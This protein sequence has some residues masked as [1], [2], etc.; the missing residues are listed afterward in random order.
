M[1]RLRRFLFVVALLPMCA[2]SEDVK[3][4]QDPSRSP[5]IGPEQRHL[6]VGS[7]PGTHDRPHTERHA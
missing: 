4:W 2:I 1:L 5:S 7:C 3:V 6:P